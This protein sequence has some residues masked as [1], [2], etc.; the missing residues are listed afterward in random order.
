MR[1]LPGG[2]NMMGAI[3]FMFPNRL[4]IYLHDTPAK[5]L[6]NAKDRLKSSGCVRV[7][8]AARLSRWLYGRDVLGTAA[9]PEQRI[10]IPNPV[11][12]YITYLTAAPR[13]G[14]IEYQADVYARDAELETQPR[15]R[16]LA[17]GS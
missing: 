14:R 2:D 17:R 8:D 3:K 12:V 6:F 15:S 1:Q 11:P 16:S 7:E 13:N 4:G 10:D 5:T 9:G